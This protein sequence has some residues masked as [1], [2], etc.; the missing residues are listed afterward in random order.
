ME[1]SGLL[2]SEIVEDV[3]DNQHDER[4]EAVLKSIVYCL[5]IGEDLRVGAPQERGQLAGGSGHVER[6]EQNT[7]YV[8]YI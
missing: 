7:T 3:D 5:F 4:E 2:L 1:G 6:T 8:F